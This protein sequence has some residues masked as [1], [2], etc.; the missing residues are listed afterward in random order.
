MASSIIGIMG[1]KRSGKDTFADRL[2]SHHGF[3]RLALADPMRE[4]ALALDPLIATDWQDH[5]LVRLSF[6]V[7]TIGWERAKGIG[8]VRRTLQRLGT[9][10]GRGILGED[11]W[12]HKTLALAAAMSGPVV[13]TDVR[14]DNE[15]AAIDAHGVVVRVTRPGLTADTWH[16]SERLATDFSVPAYAE[17]VNE[18]TVDDLHTL[19][20]FLAED[21]REWLLTD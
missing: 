11:L 17:I 13:V 20:D 5:Y 3:T 8:E 4:F 18:G 10:A 7:D 1:L 15:R 2:V 14:F 9:E 12:V 16:S 21:L 19:A 6:I